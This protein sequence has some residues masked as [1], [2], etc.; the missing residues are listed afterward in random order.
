M[1]KFHLHTPLL[2]PLTQETHYTLTLYRRAKTKK[3]ITKKTK[4][5]VWQPG[6]EPGNV[7]FISGQRIRSYIQPRVH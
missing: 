7:R 2:L 1:R 3:K 4:K 6:F 5:T